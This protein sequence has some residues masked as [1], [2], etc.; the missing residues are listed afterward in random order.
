MYR[1]TNLI[2]HNDNTTWHKSILICG[3]NKLIHEM[4]NMM[5]QNSKPVYN[6]TAN[7][8]IAYLLRDRTLVCTAYEPIYKGN[9][10][11]IRCLSGCL[12]CFHAKSLTWLAAL[13]S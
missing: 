7:N 6:N 2:I 13:L 4:N 5:Y 9:H 3:V 1:I 11:C 8:S 12:P 10:S